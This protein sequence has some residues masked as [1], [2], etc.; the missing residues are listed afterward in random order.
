MFIHFPYVFS[1]HVI[2]TSEG[3]WLHQMHNRN[4]SH[5]LDVFWCKRTSCICNM[6]TWLSPKIT[7]K[8]LQNQTNTTLSFLI[9]ENKRSDQIHF[10]RIPYL[11]AASGTPFYYLQG[12]CPTT[13]MAIL[14]Y[15]WGHYHL[16]INNHYV[17]LVSTVDGQNPGIIGFHTRPNSLP[18]IAIASSAL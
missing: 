2:T 16:P 4:I 13:Q 17:S 10:E 15:F 5:W 9:R 18:W 7:L 1:W 11:N 8:L 3:T 12:I 14:Q 6:H